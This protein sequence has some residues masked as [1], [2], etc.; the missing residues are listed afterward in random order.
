MLALLL[1]AVPL[2]ALAGDTTPLPD[3]ANH[4]KRGMTK[5]QAIQL[6]GPA[7][8]AILPKDGG[9]YKLPDPRIALE[10]YW[11]NTPCNPVVVQFDVK[12]RVTGWD[13]GTMFCEKEIS[14]MM[15]PPRSF[16]CQKGDR[17]KTCR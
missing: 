7:T 6:L 3:S 14:A 5:A 8:W 1:A 10:L 15:E 9:D 4:L 2:I 13:L 16:S 17:A 12:D 11:R